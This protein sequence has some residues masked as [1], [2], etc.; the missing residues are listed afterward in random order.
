[1]SVLIEIL[2]HA[3]VVNNLADD[4]NVLH[5]IKGSDKGRGYDL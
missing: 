3:A 2:F 1:M 4:G 5:L